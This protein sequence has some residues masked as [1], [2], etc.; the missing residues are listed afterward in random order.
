MKELPDESIDM[1]LCKA[2]IYSILTNER[3]CGDVIYQKTYVE[4]CLTKK[5]KKNRGEMTKYLVTNNHP[6]IIERE[7][8]KR[9]QAEMARRGGM[10]KISDKT[11]TEQGKYSGKFALTNLLICG[12]CGSPYRR[13]S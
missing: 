11:I 4:N 8:F 2:N 9:V 12:E 1:I 6:A 7:I 3:Y 5:V 10:R 13:K